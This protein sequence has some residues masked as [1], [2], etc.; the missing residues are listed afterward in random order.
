MTV[1]DKMGILRD[2]GK[3]SSKIASLFL[4]LT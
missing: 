2:H 1:L 4:C 3:R